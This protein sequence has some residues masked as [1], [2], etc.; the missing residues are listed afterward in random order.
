MRISTAHAHDQ[1]IETLMKRQVELTDL[2]DQLTTGKRVAKASDDPA[3]AARAER[4]LAGVLRADTSQRAVEASRTVMSQTESAMADAEDLLQEAREGLVAAGNASYSDQERAGL[5]AKLRAIREQLLS[6]ANRTDGAGTYLFG[7][8]SASAVP[9]ADQPGGV[10]YQGLTGEVR[11]EGGT[12]LPLSADGSSVFM[13][14]RTGNGVYVTSAAAGV[15]GAWIDNGQVSDPGA[16]T[17]ANY[18]IQFSVSGAGTTYAGL[19]NG[20][21]TAITA[22]PYT[23]G[24]DIAVDGM[25]F[26]ISGVP[27]NGDQF[28]IAPSTPT[29]SVFD[30]LDRAINQLSTP[31]RSAAQIAQGNTDAL[32]DIDQS[33]GQMQRARAVAGEVLARI[34][35]ETSRLDTQKLANQTERSRAE[36]LDMTQAISEFQNRQTGYDAALKS[37]SM[38]QRLSLFQYLNS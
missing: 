19:Q 25:T 12:D 35:H 21:P 31:G 8:Q 15:T 33:M 20:N 32:R 7:G 26:K 13:S 17:G 16:L 38:V 2:Q 4:A 28:T 5:A 23:S 27:A 24:Q 9:F 6:V 37:Y 3:A 30:T 1:A 36:D 10:A 34:E 11:T 14:A 29:L 18:T 22:A